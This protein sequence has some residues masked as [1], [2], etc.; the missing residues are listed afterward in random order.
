MCL[1]EAAIHDLVAGFQ[2]DHWATLPDWQDLCASGVGDRIDQPFQESRW[3]LMLCTLDEL[4]PYDGGF[5]ARMT[6]SF[7]GGK[8]M[9]LRVVE[10]LRYEKKVGIVANPDAM[11]M[12]GGAISNSPN[13]R[14]LMFVVHQFAY[15]ED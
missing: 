1:T 15:A 3:A 13:D 7:E 4:I 11:E 8:S 5:H 2:Q 12:N 14:N 10:I 6:F 9:T